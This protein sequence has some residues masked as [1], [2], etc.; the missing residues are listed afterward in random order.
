MADELD[1]DLTVKQT[2]AE[3]AA[4]EADFAKAF[5]AE[6]SNAVLEPEVTPEPEPEPET[7]E[8]AAA[9]PETPAP[10]PVIKPVLAGLTED[11]ITAALA[12]ASQQQATI[13]KL[14]G[15]IGHLIQQVEQLKNTPRTVAD[16]RSFDV[17]L[18]KLSQA[19]PELAEL[20]REDLQGLT[21]GEAPV[22][23]PA[24][25]TFTA[26]DVDRIVTEKLTSFSQQQERGMEVRA[27]GSVHPDWEQVIRTP[28]FALW[29]D[30]VI[31]DGAALM[32]S[33]SA[34]FI[35]RKL[36]EF[37][38]WVKATTVAPTPAPTPAPRK[39][40]QQRLRDAILPDTPTP[41]TTGTVSEEDAFAA[42][43]ATER[44]RS[45]Y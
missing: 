1:L 45:G 41:P 31:E 9:A 40:P 26:E 15:R 37:K 43:F 2:P 18:T 36:T 35:S 30:N 33:E 14:G 17:K 42:A 10:A 21:P 11:Q 34:Q 23:A 4:E 20:L 19:F 3:A 16:Q 25:P 22:A 7:P 8:P 44:K 12:R 5:N 27:L 6:R 39:N 28:Q 38:D 24:A 29:R 13:D 32:E